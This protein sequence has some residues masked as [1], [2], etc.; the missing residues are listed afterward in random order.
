MVSISGHP[1]S[2]IEILTLTPE[3]SH[4]A[5]SVHKTLVKKGI[6][7]AKHH[8][9]TTHVG[10]DLVSSIAIISVPKVRELVDFLFWFEEE[11][12]RWSMLEDEKKGLEQTLGKG[13]ASVDEKNQA[14]SRM[15]EV[16]LLRQVIPSQRSAS[17]DVLHG[18]NGEDSEMEPPKYVQ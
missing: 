17:G 18:R 2:H 12:K 5:K 3:T 15:M 7:D 13:D 9:D 10:G 8:C 14:E 11:C 6:L 1:S 4:Y 16:N